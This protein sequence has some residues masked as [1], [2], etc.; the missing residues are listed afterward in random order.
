MCPSCSQQQVVPQQQ[1]NRPPAP[2][3]ARK[4]PPARPR[5]ST[6]TPV[7]PTA[8][9]SSMSVFFTVAA[10]LAAI[11]GVIVLVSMV[12][13]DKP[14][15]SLQRGG[16]VAGQSRGG[17]I[18]TR[19]GSHQES[20]GDTEAASAKGKDHK[21]VIT[22]SEGKSYTNCTIEKADG[23]W[24]IVRHDRGVT[25][26]RL[27]ELPADLR[28]KYIAEAM[29]SRKTSIPAPPT[30]PRSETTTTTKPGGGTGLEW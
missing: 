20:A 14:Q 3:P 22:T 19:A 1:V 13:H 25:K 15:D 10:V 21:A 29:S 16:T 24:A 12:S 23:D 5:R 30:T 28:A 8:K 27:F 9:K 6:P 7:P 17:S 4:L 18:S 11:V 26:V 2:S